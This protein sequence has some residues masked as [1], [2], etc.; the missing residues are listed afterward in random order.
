MAQLTGQ[1]D[2]QLAAGV[3]VGSS[4]SLIGSTAVGVAK[5]VAAHCGTA[6]GTV[7]T[8]IV[9]GLSLNPFLSGVALVGSVGYL[10]YKT[11]K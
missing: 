3:A 6:F 5:T 4:A 11:C 8:G 7:K 2:E 10:I 9:F 1:N